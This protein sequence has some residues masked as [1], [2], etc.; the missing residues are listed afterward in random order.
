MHESMERLQRCAGL[1]LHIDD[2][3]DGHFDALL[4]PNRAVLDR[5]A[6]LKNS[7]FAV[8]QN[9]LIDQNFCSIGLE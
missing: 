7:Q 1:V 9:I 8:L 2:M 4:H 3:W 5:G 6:V